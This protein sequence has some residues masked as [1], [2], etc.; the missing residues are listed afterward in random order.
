MEIERGRTLLAGE[1][2]DAPARRPLDQF[3]VAESPAVANL[4]D[5]LRFVRRLQV[6]PIA[7]I[8]LVRS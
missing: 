5:R 6:D 4:G 3:G 7:V 1:Q 2:L 8:R